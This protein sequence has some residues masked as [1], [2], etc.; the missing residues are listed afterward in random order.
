MCSEQE[1][2]MG[3][4]MAVLAFQ[5][6]H[7]KRLPLNEFSTAEK[8]YT[9]RQERIIAFFK[10]NPDPI[11][12]SELSKKLNISADQLRRLCRALV[13]RGSLISTRTNTGVMYSKSS[14]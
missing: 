7:K 13:V 14:H 8:S 6:G 4:Q 3:L 1:Y 10:K 2:L 9:T 12:R 11:Y 5:E